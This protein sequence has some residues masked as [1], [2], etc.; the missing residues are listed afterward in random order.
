MQLSLFERPKP[1]PVASSDV[2]YHILPATEK[3]QQFAHLIA[4]RARTSVPE[5]VLGDRQRLSAWIEANKAK[6][7]ANKYE[8]YPS[9]KQVGFAERIAR[10]KRRPIPPECFRDK[11]L[12]SKWIDANR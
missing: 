11:A 9:S 10:S 6:K 1:R 7:S 12:M 5:D 8:R 3:Q 2:D 4:K